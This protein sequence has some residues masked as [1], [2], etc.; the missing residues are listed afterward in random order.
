MRRAFL[1]C[2]LSG[3]AVVA[4]LLPGCG[5]SQNDSDATGSDKN[6]YSA[7]AGGSGA[8]HYVGGQKCAEC[9]DTEWKLWQGSH[10][11]QAMAAASADTVL[12][13]F[14]DRELEHFGTTTRFFQRDN[15]YWV[16][17][18]GAD[19]TVQ[20]FQVSWVFGVEPL[21]Q[22][23]VDFDDGRKQ[24][25]PY[26]WDSRPA[27]QGGQ[28]WFH[29]HP[30]EEVPPS[31]L[32]HWTKSSQNWNFMCAECHSTGLTRGY[33][34]ESD[35]FDTQWH[36]IDV[37]CESCHGPG[38]THLAWADA[39]AQDGD[40]AA[41][42]GQSVSAEEM[43]L[44]PL[45]NHDGAI[46]EIDSGS[47]KPKRNPPLEA[48]RE[49]NTCA[50]CHSRRSPLSD[51]HEPG[52]EFLDDYMPS[53]LE[54]LLYHADGQIL[55]EVYVWGS[56]VQ[57][58]MHHAG[59]SC[60]DCHNAH[61]LK[62]KFE[63]DNLCL[64]CHPS[65][66]FASK[67]HHGHDPFA[68]GNSFVSCVDCHMPETTYMVN[69]PRRDHSMRVPRPDLSVAIGTPNACNGCHDD[70]TGQ[71]AVEAV[72]EWATGR[73][74]AGEKLSSANAELWPTHYATALHKGRVGAPGA[75]QALRDVAGDASQ[76]AIARASALIEYS[77]RGYPGLE[78]VV[79][80]MPDE[81]QTPPLLDPDPLLRL[82][83]AQAAAG[84]APELRVRIAVSLLLDPVRAIRHEAVR[85]ILPFS[86][87]M[88][89]DGEVYDLF[90]KELASYQ[91]T[92][93]ATLDR[94]G[95]RLN[96]GLMYMDLGQT[97]QAE[98]E[99]RAALKLEPHYVPAAINLADLMRDQQR[100]EEGEKTLRRTLEKEPG[101]ADLLHSLGLLLV[102]S[103]RTD[104]AVKQLQAAATAAPANARYALVLG[105]AHESY[106]QPEKARAAYT[107]G[108]MSSP[109]DPELLLAM[110]RLCEQDGDL[111]AAKSYARRFL[112]ARP[113]HQLGADLSTWQTQNE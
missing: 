57:S 10:H 46:W 15:A 43:G 78:Y 102:R 25:L 111:E 53:L 61:S 92:L 62:L 88:P 28:R 30:N 101:N 71:W 56:F 5:Q 87:Q 36:E 16:S 77:Q 49:V 65:E 74:E 99:Y 34:E 107:R 18:A 3:G 2:A 32:L 85:Q 73:N 52:A 105:V 14:Q 11:D 76:P 48:H 27:D 39:H 44:K 42:D 54:P 22:Y 60:S 84:L 33:H 47:G 93:E 103:D 80:T 112:Q 86:D 12:G 20:D 9:H 8:A 6:A 41:Q 82:G 94:P 98:A 72:E 59:V 81:T 100:D 96:R 38:S 68:G 55:D 21:Q 91:R 95:T 29:I 19:G 106:E 113:D 90:Q 58:K 109:W 104:E 23:L 79:A 13:D 64:Q 31:D 4:V 51:G 97:E 66:T 45:V 17:T 1:A 40:I 110:F 70:Q 75:Q 50:P 7:E 67:K 69:D 89:K 24:V 35:T 63:G 108:L 26:C 37:S 83:A